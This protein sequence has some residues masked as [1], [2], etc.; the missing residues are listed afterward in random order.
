MARHSEKIANSYV[1]EIILQLATNLDGIRQQFRSQG[2]TSTVNAA[3]R[4]FASQA[5]VGK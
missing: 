2:S 4:R 5:H 1:I 3:S